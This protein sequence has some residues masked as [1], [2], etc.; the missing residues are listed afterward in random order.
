STSSR[1][2]GV[3]CRPFHDGVF[4]TGF[5][6]PLSENAME[7]IPVTHA[8]S[9]IRPAELLS[10]LSAIDQGKAYD[11]AAYR[12]VL[13]KAVAAWVPR[14]VEVG[15]DIVDDGEMGKSTWIT[16]LYER[17]PAPEPKPIEGP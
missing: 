15:V 8:G 13:S 1:L 9:L 2:T 16:D 17:M 14:Q 7:R 6:M 11:S 4:H 3:R 5:T 10:F 12:A